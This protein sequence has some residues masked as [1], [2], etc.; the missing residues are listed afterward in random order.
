MASNVLPDAESDDLSFNDDSLYAEIDKQNVHG[1]NLDVPEGARATIKPWDQREDTT[2][3]ADSGVDDQVIIHVP[4]NHGVRLRAIL[5]KL[6]RGDHTPRHLR[7]YANRSTI[8]DFADAEDITPNLD[9][10]LLD[11]QTSVTEYPLRAAAF[12]NVSSVS[13]YF[14]ESTGGDVSRIYYIGFKGDNRNLVREAGNKLATPAANAAD[15][16]L[17]DRASEKAGSK[18]TTAR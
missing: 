13:L 7:I 12:A 15:A 6:G 18:Q 11:G 2:T 10:T 14:N 3:F 16:S 8:V 1:L 5:L 9:I 17:T 4:F